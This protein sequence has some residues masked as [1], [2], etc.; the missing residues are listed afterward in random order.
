MA[1]T[2]GLLAQANINY[3]SLTD[4]YTVPTG[5]SAIITAIRVASS[6]DDNSRT[7]SVKIAGGGAADTAKHTILGTRP[8]RTRQ[9][10]ELRGIMPLA[11]ADVVRVLT[12][13]GFSTT[14]DAIGQVYGYDYDPADASHKILGQLAPSNNTLSALYTVPSLKKATLSVISICNTGGSKR[15][16]RFAVDKTGAGDDVTD[17]LWYD[18]PIYPGHTVFEPIGLQIAAGGILRCYTSS[19]EVV[20]NAFGL[21]EDA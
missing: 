6:E 17:Y 8:H 16:F 1:G 21:E 3:N 4:L 5:H 18:A 14:P 7:T 12:N 11:A 13:C 19:S 9:T 20:F 15:T 2:P 10:L